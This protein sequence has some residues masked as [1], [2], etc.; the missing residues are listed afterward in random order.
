VKVRT[1]ALGVA[2][3][4]SAVTGLPGC[5]GDRQAATV[6]VAK[7]RTSTV[8]ET[9]EGKGDRA[10]SARKRG[11]GGGLRFR[12]KGDGTLPRIHVRRGGATLRWR[13]D[14]EVFSLFS[15]QGTLVDSVSRQGETSLRPGRHAI[16]VIASGAWLVTVSNARR[17]R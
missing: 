7:T 15:E 6:T 9:V 3:V 11:R 16:D 4:V 13:N 1:I 2:V 17:A 8:T 10:R 12:G 14:G 5:G